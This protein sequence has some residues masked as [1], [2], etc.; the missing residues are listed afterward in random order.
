MNII[1]KL[2]F[3]KIGVV[4]CT[5]FIVLGLFQPALACDEYQ[6]DDKKQE[7]DAYLNCLANKKNCLENKL[8]EV[9]QRKSTLTNAISVII[10]KIKPDECPMFLKACTPSKPVGACMVSSEGTCRVWAKTMNQ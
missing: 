9:K 6:C 1:P 5:L 3:I 2:K 7:V 10:G 4:F 8:T